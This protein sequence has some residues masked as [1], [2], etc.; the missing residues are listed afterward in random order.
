MRVIL[1]LLASLALAAC[2]QREGPTRPQGAGDACTH[3][4]THDVSW[5]NPDAAD[6]VTATSQGPS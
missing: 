2:V 1:F 6:T 3:S 5:S 4:A